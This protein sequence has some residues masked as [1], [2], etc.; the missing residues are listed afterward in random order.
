MPAG[1]FSI[2]RAVILVE[3]LLIQTLHMNQF[4]LFRHSLVLLFFFWISIAVSLNYN[5]T[6]KIRNCPPILIKYAEI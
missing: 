2:V 3:Y 5:S 4:F 1:Y 6:T